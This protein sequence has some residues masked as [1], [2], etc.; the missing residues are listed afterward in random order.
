MTPELTRLIEEARKKVDAM[1]PAEKR[2]MYEMQRKS[3]FIGEWMLEHP[4]CS[5][6]EAERRY[7]DV[8]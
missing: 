8:A 1:T 7:H 2:E 4:E 3:W 5:R 6:E